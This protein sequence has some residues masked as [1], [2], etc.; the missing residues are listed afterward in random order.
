MIGIAWV[1]TGV[2]ADGNAL[3]EIYELH[4]AP[5]GYHA[6]LREFLIAQSDEEDADSEKTADGKD[7]E[8]SAPQSSSGADIDSKNFSIEGMVLYSYMANMYRD[9]QFIDS[10]KKSEIRTRLKLKY[11]TES[12]YVYGVPNFYFMTTFVDERIGED[13]VYSKNPEV[14]RNL[15]LS[16]KASEA[17]FN[18]LYVNFGSEKV[19]LRIGNQIYAWGTADVMNPTSYFN[20]FDAREFLFKEED[21]M[22]YGI[23]SASAMFYFGT[24]VLEVVYAPIHVPMAIPPEGN[25]WFPRIK[26]V[27]VKILLE[28]QK[29]LEISGKN[30]A[31]GARF[32]GKIW[33]IDASLSAYHGPDKEPVFVPIAIEF[34]PN[35][36]MSISVK[37][38]YYRVNKFGFDASMDINKFVVQCEASYSPDKHGLSEIPSD[39]YE[40]KLPIQV[41]KSH[42]VS[43]SAGFNYFIPMNK[44]IEGHDGD[45][46]FTFEW[47]QSFF[48]KDEMEE[49]ILNKMIITR[50]EDTYLDSKLKLKVTFIYETR[51]RGYIFWPKAEWDFQNGLSVEISYANIQGN[52]DSF[53]YYYS[54]KDILLWKVRYTF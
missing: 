46:V 17:D 1:A 32:S 37:P 35:E 13:Y 21:E 53:L 4:I 52:E 48:F 31:Y 16:T 36:L 49:P 22:Y 25:F 45:S 15:R 40:V 20:P 12:T 50:I 11:G 6:D 24:Y 2:P 51:E 29:G 34:P 8:N 27:P 9:Q 26:D 33:D 41:R 43:Y 19:R 38:E 28:E 18:E 47:D 23:P 3:N 10:Q 30:M 14:E 54:D 39:L 44:I 42:Y 5:W 7:K